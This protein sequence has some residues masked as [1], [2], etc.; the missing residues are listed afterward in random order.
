MNTITLFKYGEDLVRS[1]D[2]GGE[3]YF[4]AK[5]VATVLGYSNTNKAISDH[6]KNSVRDGVTIRDS[7]GRMQTASIIPE[8]DVYRLIMRSKLPT[9][10]KFEDWVVG[11]VLPSIR[12][13]GEY[14]SINS[15]PDFNDPVAA[16]RAWADE[17]EMV[18][19]QKIEIANNAPKVEFVNK[20][21]ERDT[22]VNATQVGLS[23]GLSA[24][25]LNN[26]LDKFGGVYNKAVKRGRVFTSEWVRK[27]YGEMKV[28]STG[29]NQPLFTS[30]G[31]VKINEMLIAQG[32]V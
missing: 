23:H 11:E 25:A 32:V 19:R 15:L 2:R 30:A 28:G 17:R 9:A 27:G 20:L 5:D 6:C 4:V 10:E 18:E 14:N 26:L 24:K 31:Q 21:V 8:R 13:T 22:L 1:F 16:A 12:K 29:H 7:M 3:I